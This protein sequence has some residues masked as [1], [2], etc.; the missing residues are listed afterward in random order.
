MVASST[1]PM[2]PS[3][4]STLKPV[5]STVG[6]AIANDQISPVAIEPPL[7]LAPQVACHRLGSSRL[8]GQAAT[9]P[10]T[11]C[12]THERPG[13]LVAAVYAQ[14]GECPTLCVGMTKKERRVYEDRD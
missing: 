11:G 6:A 4:A 5:K 9:K 8:P 13:R 2:L 14:R 10:G 12:I 7:R 3:R 1:L